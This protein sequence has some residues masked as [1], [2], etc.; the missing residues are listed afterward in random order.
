MLAIDTF[1]DCLEYIFPCTGLIYVGAG[2]GAVFSGKRFSRLPRLLAIEADY[3]AFTNL[4]H[5]LRDRPDFIPLKALISHSDSEAT[6]FVASNPKES[7]LLNPD[8]LKTVWRNLICR[9][10]EARVTV[11]LSTVLK[12]EQ[13]C[14]VYNWLSIDCFPSASILLGLQ[15]KINQFDLIDLRVLNYSAGVLEQGGTKKECDTLLNPLGYQAIFTEEA[16][17]P[18]VQ[19]VLYARNGRACLEIQVG[20]IRQEHQA[21]VAKL[22]QAKIEAEKSLAERTQQEALLRSSINDELRKAE[23]QLMLVTELLLPESFV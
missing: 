19:R 10:E 23:A 17:N 14:D 8:G 16:S 20:Q 21:L 3:Q 13:K 6:F 12:N 7:G 22:T 11:T 2:N 1:I 4:S 18:M 5:S 9:G 15:G